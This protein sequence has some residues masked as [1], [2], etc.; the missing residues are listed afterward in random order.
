MIDSILAC[1]EDAK[2]EDVR[3]FD[4]A[5]RSALADTMIIATGR[6][7]THVGALA[8]RIDRLSRECGFRI[9]RTQGMPLNDWVLVDLGDVIIHLLRPEIRSFYT[10]EALWT[11]DRAQTRAS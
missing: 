4:M 1:L 7:N 2:A 6:S 3:V 11:E 8:D 5:G 10:L 9:L